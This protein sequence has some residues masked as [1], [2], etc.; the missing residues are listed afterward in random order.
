MTPIVRFSLLLCWSVSQA[1]DLPPPAIHD[2]Q[3]LHLV[4]G[5][6]VAET[7]VLTGKMLLGK[8]YVHQTLD[9]NRTEQLVVNLQQFDC[10][11]FL[12]TTLAL[13]L[14][15]HESI[16]KNQEVFE[17]AFIQQL[18]RLRYR[19]G[20]INGYGSR[21]HYLSDWLR[22]NVQKG[23]VQD[24]TRE[25]GG[26][27]VSKS[28]NYMTAA[29]Y[30]YPHLSDP[31]VF[32]Q[33]ADVQTDI[34]RQPFWFIPKKQIAAIESKLQEGDIIML[35][36]ARPGLDMKHVGFCVWQHGR[37]HLLHASS[38]YGEVMI[39]PVPLA[40]YIGINKRLSGIRVARLKSLSQLTG[41]QSAH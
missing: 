28:L 21:L 3:Q 39:T 38:E 6:T 8:S 17:Q 4:G 29:V 22:D 11:T 33:I 30:K 5:R 37:V 18:T 13:S 9:G 26:M 10:T 40:T 20:Q 34:S 36:A 25:I 24:I 35:T 19:H 31:M 7:A 12:E 16:G 2:L 14:A 41:G 1:Q 32:K 23:I 27:Q 15:W